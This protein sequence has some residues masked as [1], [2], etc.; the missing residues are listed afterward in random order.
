MVAMII[1][2]II[3]TMII[4]NNMVTMI[5]TNIIVTHL[6]SRQPSHLRSAIEKGS[7]AIW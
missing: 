3:V 4:T 5:I 2:N 7:S 1:T 6:Q